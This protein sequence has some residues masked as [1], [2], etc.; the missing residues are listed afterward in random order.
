MKF[1]GYD[2]SVPVKEKL[3]NMKSVLEKIESNLENK[4]KFRNENK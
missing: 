4:K 1:E 3:K 2:K